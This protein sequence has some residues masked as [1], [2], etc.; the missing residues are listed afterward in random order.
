MINQLF[1]LAILVLGVVMLVTNFQID[2]AL[3]GQH[4]EDVALNNANKGILVLAVAAMVSSLAYM[5]C[6]VK[7]SDKAETVLA[8]ELYAG[9]VLVIGIV[10]ISLGSIVNSRAGA[11]SDCAA[12]KH[13]ANAVIT[14]GVIMTVVCGSYLGWYAYENLGG[15]E[16]V[17]RAG[18]YMKAKSSM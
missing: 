16:A 4:C 18:G 10:L 15:R 3:R 1:S 8:T 2:H 12:A 6:A 14:L 11:V 5:T 7:C 17:N 13:H 9:F